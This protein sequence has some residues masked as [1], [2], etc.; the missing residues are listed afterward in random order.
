MLV[1][2]NLLRRAKPEALARLA[3]SLGV[4]VGPDHRANVRRVA[5][6]VLRDTVAGWRERAAEERAQREEF[7]MTIMEATR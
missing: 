2:A 5:R 3:R 1:D 6:A 4:D 7:E